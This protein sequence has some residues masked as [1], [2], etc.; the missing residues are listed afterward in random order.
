[1]PNSTGPCP[2]CTRLL[3]FVDS[4]PLNE[5]QILI[6]A[7]CKTCHKTFTYISKVIEPSLT[8]CEQDSAQ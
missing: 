2:I 4:R 1:M 8:A 6:H 7:H 3:T 5:S